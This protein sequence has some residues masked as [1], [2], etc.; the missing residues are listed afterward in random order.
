MK[1]SSLEPQDIVPKDKPPHG[2]LEVVPEEGKQ[3]VED[4]GL[5]PL[6]SGFRDGQAFVTSTSIKTLN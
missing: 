5:E 6:P 4:P 3:T 1:M 2:D